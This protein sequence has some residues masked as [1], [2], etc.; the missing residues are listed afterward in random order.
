MAARAGPALGMGMGMGMGMGTPR[1]TRDIPPSHLHFLFYGGGF[2]Y[3][4]VSHHKKNRK[5]W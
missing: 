4:R 3:Q 2:G 1:L 5:L